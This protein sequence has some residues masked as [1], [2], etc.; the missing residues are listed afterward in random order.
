MNK[1]QAIAGP[2]AEVKT[3]GN[4]DRDLSLVSAH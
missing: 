2:S 4:R 1:S 3:E